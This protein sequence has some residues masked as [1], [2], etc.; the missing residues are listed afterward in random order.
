MFIYLPFFMMYW[1]M[2]PYTYAEQAI[3]KDCHE[4]SK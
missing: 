4:V 2:V 3:R 1:M